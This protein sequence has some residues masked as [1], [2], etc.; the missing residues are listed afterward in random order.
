[1]DCSVYVL[2]DK[3]EGEMGVLV[4]KM[5][6][7]KYMKWNG[8]NGFVDGQDKDLARDQLA[9][10]EEQM[11]QMEV[12][13]EHNTVLLGAIV[14]SDEEDEEDEEAEEEEEEDGDDDKRS[15]T[16]AAAAASVGHQPTVI[17][18]SDI[19]QAFSHFTHRYTKRKKMVRDLQGVLPHPS[20]GSLQ[21]WPLAR[22][23]SSVQPVTPRK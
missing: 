8:N 9:A 7:G 1:M 3:T 2:Q 12:S 23:I 13:T 10:L 20:E 15:K 19:P 5:L 6:T 21:F 18:E 17:H 22:Q 4:E 11:Q 16:T 14:E